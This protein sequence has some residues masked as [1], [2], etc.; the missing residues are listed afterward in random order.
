[1]P[2]RH[3]CA[4]PALTHKP[5]TL[6][7]GIAIPCNLAPPC[8]MMAAVF[9]TLTGSLWAQRHWA[10]QLEARQQECGRLR[11][12]V[13]DLEQRW[14]RFC[15]FAP[16]AAPPSPQQQPPVAVRPLVWDCMRALHSRGVTAAH[17][18]ARR[19]LACTLTVS[20]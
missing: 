20:A 12:R 7:G 8:S 6:G 16:L 4:A 2:A 15:T 3:G 19:L 18:L 5:H 11:G 1:M 13:R 14:A 10:A 17:S 9:C